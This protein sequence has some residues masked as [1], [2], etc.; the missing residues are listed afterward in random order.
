MPRRTK[1]QQQRECAYAAIAKELA[2]LRAQ[3][4]AASL[5][6]G[7]MRGRAQVDAFAPADRTARHAWL[8]ALASTLLR[9]CGEENKSIAEQYL[10]ALVARRRRGERRAHG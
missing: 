8:T 3:S 6:I 1:G 9:S 5:E 2:P 7:A 10:D 4:D